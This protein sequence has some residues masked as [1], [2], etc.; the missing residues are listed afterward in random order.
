M[1]HRSHPCLVVRRLRREGRSQR[2]SCASVL[3]CQ[4]NIDHK[5]ALVKKVCAQ[6]CSLNVARTVVPLQTAPTEVQGNNCPMLSALITRRDSDARPC[7]QDCT[8]R[9]DGLRHTTGTTNNGARAVQKCQLKRHRATQDAGPSCGPAYEGEPIHCSK[10]RTH[11]ATGLRKHLK[12][13]SRRDQSLRA[14]AGSNGPM[15]QITMA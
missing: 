5:T 3:C 15:P 6:S 13:R 9:D 11:R 14:P 12:N 10:I 7:S 2:A 8:G 4:G 1:S